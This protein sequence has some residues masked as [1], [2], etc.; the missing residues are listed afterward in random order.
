VTD[1]RL[2]TVVSIAHFASHVFQMAL[3][4][5]FPVLRAE[6]D[7]NYVALGLLMTVYYSVSAVGQAVA[8]FLVDRFGAR[9]MLL[10]GTTLFAGSIVSAGLA[11]SFP[12]L[13]AVALVGALGNSVFHPADYAIFSAAIDGRRLGRA[14]SAPGI[15]GSLGFAIGPALI[16]GLAAVVGWRGALLTLGSAGLVWVFVLA[17]QTRDLL[18]HRRPIAEPERPRQTALSADFRVLLS[19]PILAAFAYFAFLATATTGL[20]TFSVPALMAIYA[21]PLGAA[22]SA[23]TGYL[24]GKSAGVLGG[25]FIVDRTARH[26]VLAGG[27]M[28]IAAVFMLF[29]STGATGMT[30]VAIAMTLAGFSIGVVQ[31]A[32]DMLVRAAT[33]AGSSGKVFGFA[34]SGLDL[35]AALTPVAFGWLMDH[36]QPRTLFVV[37]AVLMVLTI[38]TVV[39]VRRRAATGAGALNPLERTT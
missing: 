36:G 15:G 8:G 5:L 29:V 16:V 10:I 12:V 22:T 23:L 9:R 4:P 39:E 7:V 28:L 11:G 31:P 26:D 34:Y 17:Y 2:I 21:T 38:G 27:G 35:G 30:A 20:S 1:V 37:I 32:R 33:P 13:F 3:P 25:G 6:F 14:F 24:V 18:D 19:A